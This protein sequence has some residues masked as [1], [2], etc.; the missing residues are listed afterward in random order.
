MSIYAGQNAKV[1]RLPKIVTKIKTALIRNI[2]QIYIKFKIL[3][4][5]N[6]Y[7]L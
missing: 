7:R 3:L 4:T 1:R 6:I 2:K 5:I